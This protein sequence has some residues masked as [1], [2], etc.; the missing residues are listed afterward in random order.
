VSEARTP[1]LACVRIWPPP[2]PARPAPQRP[3]ALRQG[4]RELAR[5]AAE[6]RVQARRMQ[7]TER[8]SK[9]R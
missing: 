2:Q 8:G 3:E 9:N 6:A 4:A 5:L 7:Q 1:A